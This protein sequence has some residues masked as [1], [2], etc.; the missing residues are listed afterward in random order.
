[1]NPATGIVSGMTDLITGNGDISDISVNSIT[2]DDDLGLII[3]VLEFSIGM[4]VSSYAVQVNG[5]RW[6]GTAPEAVAGGQSSI[7]LSP[8]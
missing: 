4:T 5:T 7:T 1:M 6:S 2:S 3:T 8:P